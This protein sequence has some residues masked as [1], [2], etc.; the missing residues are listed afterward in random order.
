MQT[1]RQSLIESGV[2]I[3]AGLGIAYVLNMTLLSW[4]GSPISHG[5][6]AMLSGVMTGASLCRSYIL[7]RLFN[8]WHK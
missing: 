3:A 1:R 6:N 4:L 7:R 5:Q 8:R 2:N